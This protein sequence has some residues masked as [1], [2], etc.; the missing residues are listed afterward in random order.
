MRE[1]G[2][3]DPRPPLADVA[4]LLVADGR[5]RHAAAI[6]GRRPHGEAAPPAADL[7]HVIGG[8]EPQRPADAIDLADLRLLER[9]GGR[10]EVAARVHEQLGV[11]K[12][13]EEVVAEIVVPTDVPAAAGEGVVPEAA[14]QP[15]GEPVQRAGDAALPLEHPPVAEH[16]PHER[17]EIRRRPVAIHEGLA[18][19]DV[20]ARQR[21]QEEP[22]VVDRRRS[23]PARRSPEAIRAVRA[24]HRQRS[25]RHAVET[26]E[27]RRLRPLRQHAHHS[28]HEPARTAGAAACA[29]RSPTPSP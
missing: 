9:V 5:G 20:A 8:R 25:A 7:E 2:L 15:A 4:I 18:E 26:R 17:H 28:I 12:E 1:P 3:A 24:L 22:L 10:L 6:V 23:H 19:A 29:A 13:A 21:A 27:K 14:R 16:Q 11:E